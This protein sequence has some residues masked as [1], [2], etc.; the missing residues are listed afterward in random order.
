MGHKKRKVM[1]M[2]KEENIE[3]EV[4][5][6]QLRGLEKTGVAVILFL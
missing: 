6:H 2:T 4:T 5:H 1:I 3:D